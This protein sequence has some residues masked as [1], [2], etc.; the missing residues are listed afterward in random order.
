MT[1]SETAQAIQATRNRERQSGAGL[2]VRGV[3]LIA[4]LVAVAA[5][6]IVSLRIGSIE[7][8]TGDA[9][10]ALF[11]YDSD[12]YNQTV[13]R[14]LRLPR[15]IIALGV[16]AALATAGATMQAVT[17]NPL[18]DPSILGVSSGAT[19]AIVMATF[20]LR[21][22]APSQYVW[23][24]FAGALL[25][26]LLVFAIG[27]AG[28]G[29]P[30]PIKLALAG[31]VISALLGSWTS[32]LLLLDE[33][34]LD[35]VRF[36]LAGSVVG[37][38]LDTFWTLSPFL[39]GG[40][41]AMI[42]LGHQLNVLNLG[43][44]SARALGMNTGRMRLI[45]SLLVV[46]VVGAAVSAAGPIAFVGLATPHIVRAVIGPDYRWVLPYSAITGAILLTAADVAGR[47]VAR[48]AEIQVGIMTAVVGA[49]FLIYLAR[50]RTV[51][52]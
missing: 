50:Q 30:S 34:T 47:I 5:I 32:A 41:L 35:T 43:E 21:L 19:F 22:S 20:Y 17:R 48:P 51:E 31:V 1:A 46:I 27:S 38:S 45:C 49:P 28:R 13:V 6:A 23:F 29:G 44:E 11:N 4:G 3:G 26:S 10:A 36:W 52:A 39:L 33:N 15:T 14:T 7:I 25:A 24:A 8:S 37:R 12:V 40:T 18:A 42:F 9:W 2:A 16:G